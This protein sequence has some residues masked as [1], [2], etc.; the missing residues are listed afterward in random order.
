MIVSLAAFACRWVAHRPVAPALFPDELAQVERFLREN[1]ELG[2]VYDAH[3]SSV[4]RRVLLPR[5]RNHLY[6]RY[7]VDRDELTV[8]APA[9]HVVL[10]DDSSRTAT[11]AAFSTVLGRATTSL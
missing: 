9:E 8:L 7:R 5:T 1:P 4:V 3:S 6:Y 10:L 11:R 2:S